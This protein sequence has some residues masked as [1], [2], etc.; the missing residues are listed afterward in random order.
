MTNLIPRIF[1]MLL[2]GLFMSGG[3]AVIYAAYG[4]TTQLRGDADNL[5]VILICIFMISGFLILG[6][7]L[8]LFSILIGVVAII[9][10]PLSKNEIN[11]L[12]D[13]DWH[14]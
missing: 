5:F 12:N 6:V 4:F 9:G 11:A 14:Q 8:I 2:M 10:K 7:S 1:F 3:I 13:K